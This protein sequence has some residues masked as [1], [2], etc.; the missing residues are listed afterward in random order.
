MAYGTL[1]WNGTTWRFSAIDAPAQPIPT[2]PIVI[3][4]ARRSLEGTVHTHA[5]FV[6]YAYTLTFN[7]LSGT[8]T[9]LLCLRDI[10][11]RVGT[12]R[13]YDTDIGT[14]D[15]RYIPGSMKETVSGW[16]SVD[17]Q[18]RLEQV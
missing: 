11:E 3:G 4:E 16:Y 6:R 2:T 10:S 14:V 8:G 12:V 9:S 18:I 5:A 1:A 15:C 17:A 7:A 13:I